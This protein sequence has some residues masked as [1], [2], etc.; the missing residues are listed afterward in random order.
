MRVTEERTG[1]ARAA[2]LLDEV[3][4]AAPLV[5]AFRTGPEA[6]GPIGREEL[7]KAIDTLT[8]YKQGKA[9]LETRIVEDELWWELRH[10]EAIRRDKRKEGKG[11]EPSSAWL[12]NAVLNK[13]ADAM[14][15]YPEPVV[16]PREHSDEKSARALSSVLP[17]LLEY[18][19]YEQTDSD[20]WWDK[21][22]H[23]TAAYGVFWNPEKENGLGDID[24]REIDLL[25]LFW[26]CL[27]YTSDAADD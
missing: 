22:K 3:R 14:D 5:G 7:A 13:H 15:N 24:I 17:V 1:E 26:D 16:L 20:T 27:L 12:F 25:K 19:D 11:P 18:N 10:W 9:S 6:R 23:G 8:R 4:G 21:L 2:A